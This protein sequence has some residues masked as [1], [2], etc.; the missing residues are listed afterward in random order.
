MAGLGKLL[1]YS[2]NDDSLS[3]ALQTLSASDSLDFRAFLQ[4]DGAMT[5]SADDMYFALNSADSG[6]ENGSG[7]G[8]VVM[9]DAA[10]TPAIVATDQLLCELQSVAVEWKSLRQATSCSCAMPFEHHTKKVLISLLTYGSRTLRPQD[11]SAPRH[12][13]T[14]KLVPKFKPNHRW[15]CVSSELSWIEVSRLF[16]DHGTRFEVSHTTFLVSKC[17][18]IGAEV[19]RYLDAEVSCGRSVR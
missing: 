7:V 4:P 10:E 17:L 1:G 3:K 13:G 18:E 19:S 15:S 12:F 16:L 9:G 11:T 6:Y 14:T 5:D 2:Y 8:S